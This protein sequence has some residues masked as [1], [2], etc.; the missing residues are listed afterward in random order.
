MWL[1]LGHLGDIAEEAWMS[2][3]AGEDLVLRAGIRHKMDALKADLGHAAASATERLLIDRAGLTWLTLH[4][5]E[6]MKAQL[7][8]RHEVGYDAGEY[9]DRRVSAAQKRYL[10]AIH[11][12]DVHRRLVT[13]RPAPVQVA[14]ADQVN[15]AGEGAKQVNVA[16][17]T[18]NADPLPQ[19]PPVTAEPADFVFTRPV[20]EEAVLNGRA[21]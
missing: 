20:R 18:V 6:I 1:E 4:Y 21:R 7:M 13:P 2:V 17:S 19:L 5:V 8:K 9:L 16:P 3:V 11:A 10:A 15:V 12:L 14:H